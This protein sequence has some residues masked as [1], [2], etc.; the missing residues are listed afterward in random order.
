VSK[1]LI[2]ALLFSPLVMAQNKIAT[3]SPS[4]SSTVSSPVAFSAKAIGQQPYEMVLFVDG[5]QVYKKL[6][7]FNL[8]QSLLLASGAHTLTA[9]GVY[10]AGRNVYSSVHVTVGASGPPSKPPS[11][12]PSDPDSSVATQVFSDMTGQ[13]E[14][15]P[16][17]VPS[18]WDFAQG[19]VI[20]MGNNSQG[21]KAIEAW[22]V[23]YVPTSGNPATNTRVNIRNMQTYFLSKSTGKWLVLQN[24]SDP[25]GADYFEDFS[26]DSNFPADVRTEPDGSISA[27]TSAGYVFHFY[28]SDRATINPSDI[29]GIVTTLEA[30]LIVDNPAK[31]D[32]RSIAKFLVGSGADY[33]P[34]LTGSW[35][36][37]ATFDP[38]VGNGKL[39]FVDSAWRSFSMTTCTLAQLK[40]SPPPVDFTGILP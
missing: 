38:G 7:T 33:Y 21:W 24:T 31:A 39:K 16:H 17:G 25:D 32:D 6:N 34:A 20:T 2:S 4:N 22:G 10:S 23:L 27:K 5:K 26:G 18:S 3:L 12:P 19:P 36:G 37:N 14:A 15:F 29:G 9:A 28:P 11:D 30:R 1:I 35:P 13:N 40:S 8:S